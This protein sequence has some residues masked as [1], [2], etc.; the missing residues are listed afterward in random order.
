[1]RNLKQHAP[2]TDPGGIFWDQGGQ[3]MHPKGDVSCR[4][5]AELK[6]ASARNRPRRDFLGAR[7]TKNASGGRWVLQ[8]T[9]GT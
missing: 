6:T 7:R 1:M 4:A 9:C 2:G 8:G 5:H 3:K